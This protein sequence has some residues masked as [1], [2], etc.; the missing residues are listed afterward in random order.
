MGVDVMLRPLANLPDARLVIA[1]DPLDPVEPLQRLAAEL[2]VAE[3]VEWR[4]GFLPDEEIP[5]LMHEAT[6]VALPYR[7]IDSSG[8]LVTA[9][10]HGRTAVVNDVGGLAA[11]IRV[12]G[13]G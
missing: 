7:K 4:L 12:F 5:Q 10:G 13:A 8:V 2:G 11:A 1:G 6:L 3:R 9:L